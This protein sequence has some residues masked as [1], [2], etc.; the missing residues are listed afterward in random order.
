MKASCDR[1]RIF[2]KKFAEEIFDKTVILLYPDGSAVDS[3]PHTDEPFTLEKYKEQ[4]LKTMQ[5]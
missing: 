1:F 4:L 5:R 3:L 2:D